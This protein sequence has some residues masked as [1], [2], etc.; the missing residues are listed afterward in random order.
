MIW[1]P[2]AGGAAAA[3]NSTTEASNA[4]VATPKP[5]DSR[6]A[7]E[8]QR[9]GEL[10]GEQDRQEEEARNL[11]KQIL[12]EDKSSV[13]KLFQVVPQTEPS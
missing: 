9:G 3:T 8:E 4:T 6:E 11:E 5:L 12:E 7:L 2:G 10:G 13:K 1:G